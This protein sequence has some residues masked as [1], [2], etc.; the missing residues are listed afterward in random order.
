MQ[1][2]EPTTSS[3]EEKA[4]TGRAT[5]SQKAKAEQT[6]KPSAKRKK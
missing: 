5:R 2:A 6:E 1:K 3:G 4:G